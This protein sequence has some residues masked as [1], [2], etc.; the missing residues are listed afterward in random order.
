MLEHEPNNIALA[1]LSHWQND[2]ARPLSF[3]GG[4]VGGVVIK[5]VDLCVGQLSP[6]PIYHVGYG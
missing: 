1:L 3:C 4:A 5:D 6:K 2:G